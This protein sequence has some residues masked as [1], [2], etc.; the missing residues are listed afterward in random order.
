M[1]FRINLSHKPEYQN[2][3]LQACHYKPR[4]R[5]IKDSKNE[6]SIGVRQKFAHIWDNDFMNCLLE[7]KHAFFQYLQPVTATVK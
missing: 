6:I 5:R 3:H 2:L 7:K 1:S 4:L